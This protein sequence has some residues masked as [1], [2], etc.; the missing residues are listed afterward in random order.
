MSRTFRTNVLL[1]WTLSNGLL[2]AAVVS[3]TS[4]AQDS[5]AGNAVKGYMTFLLYS[6]AGLAYG[7]QSP[8]HQLE[9]DNWEFYLQNNGGVHK[10]TQEDLEDMRSLEE[11]QIEY[12]SR[13][14]QQAIYIH[15]A[16][17]MEDF[18]T[19]VVNALKGLG[20]LPANTP[21]SYKIVRTEFRSKCFKVSWKVTGGSEGPLQSVGGYQDM[22]RVAESKSCPEIKVLLEELEPVATPTPANANPGPSTANR[23]AEVDENNNNTEHPKKR[24]KKNHEMSQ[25]EEE[26]ADFVQ[27]LQEHHSCHNKECHNQPKFCLVDGS[28]KHVPLHM[29]ALKYW[30]SLLAVH[31]DGVDLDTPPKHFYFI[32]GNQESANIA[33]LARCQNSLLTLSQAPNINVHLGDLV[34]NITGLISGQLPQPQAPPQ[35]NTQAFVPPAPPAPPMQ[36]PF[37]EECKAK[38]GLSSKTIEKLLNANISGLHR[39]AYVSDDALVNKVGLS[40]GEQADVRWAEDT[41]KKGFKVQTIATVPIVSPCHFWCNPATKLI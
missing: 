31:A 39:L 25:E 32:K 18:I 11:H 8:E 21:L 41:W 6:V 5:S 14:A 35:P 30:A 17:D 15:E 4:K 22:M 26:I 1:A 19:P 37:T 27:W 36:A 34:G 3:A 12:E 9:M 20:N 33:Q 24:S 38:Y 16:S 29:R 28:G 13:L 2:A 40:I 10:Y 23:A 7:S